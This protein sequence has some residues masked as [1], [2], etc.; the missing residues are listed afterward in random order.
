MSELWSELW[1]L[2]SGRGALAGGCYLFG[3]KALPFNLKMG[4]MGI[5]IYLLAVSTSRCADPQ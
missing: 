5:G 1:S 4:T 2:L 3:I